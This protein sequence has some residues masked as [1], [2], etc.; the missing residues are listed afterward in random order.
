MYNEDPPEESGDE[1]KAKDEEMEHSSNT[2]DRDIK[3]DFF[4]SAGLFELPFS[5][6]QV[7]H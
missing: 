4:T 7:L 1:E 3:S 5:S 6:V 2:K